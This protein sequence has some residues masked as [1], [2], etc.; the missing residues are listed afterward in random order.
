MLPQ[1]K[2]IITEIY[3]FGLLS[4]NNVCMYTIADCAATEKMWP[5]EGLPFPCAVLEL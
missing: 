4:I 2:F 3:T 1:D 5:H